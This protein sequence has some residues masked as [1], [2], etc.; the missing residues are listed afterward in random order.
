M[1]IEKEVYVRR[2]F[3]RSIL[4]YEHAHVGPA[5]LTWWRMQFRRFT[6]RRRQYVRETAISGG[7]ERVVYTWIEPPEPV[8][9]AGVPT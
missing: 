2:T 1:Y 9:D 5:R 8:V 7:S 6:R 4:R 3:G